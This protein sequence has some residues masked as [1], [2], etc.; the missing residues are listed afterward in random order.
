ME[1]KV[2]CAYCG[3]EGEKSEMV[4]A[5]LIFRDRNSFTGKA[6]VN[7]KVNWYCK[8]KGC[9]GYDQMAHEG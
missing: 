7:S 1:I 9:A 4:K 3:A 6:F 8:N 2:K 5:K